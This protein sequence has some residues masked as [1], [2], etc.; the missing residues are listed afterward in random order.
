MKEKENAQTVKQHSK[1]KG[2]ANKMNKM[3]KD[4]FDSMDKTKLGIRN[5]LHQSIIDE[6]V[7]RPLYVLDI[8][9]DST[10]S[11]HTL[12][13]LNLLSMSDLHIRNIKNA[14]SMLNDKDSSFCTDV[15]VMIDFECLAFTKQ[16]IS[17]LKDTPSD[18]DIKL[19]KIHLGVEKKLDVN[20]YNLELIENIIS[21]YIKKGDLIILY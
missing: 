19:L 18:M 3:F 5:S 7:K 14:K 17:L 16:V 15:D 21:V 12:E 6:S 11:I 20:T 13:K 8:K 2:L 1:E 4:V 10:T 9:S